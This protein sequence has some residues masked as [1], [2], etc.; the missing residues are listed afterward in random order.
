MGKITQHVVFLLAGCGCK[1]QC[2]GCKRRY[3]IRDF[4]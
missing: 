2:L 4:C 3:V 1:R